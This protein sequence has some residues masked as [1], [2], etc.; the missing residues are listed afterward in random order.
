MKY[1][2]YLLE[3]EGNPE[4]VAFLSKHIPREYKTL[5]EMRERARAAELLF[6]VKRKD[7]SILLPRPERIKAL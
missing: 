3:F 2:R 1:R 4:V 5:R 6:D 7:A